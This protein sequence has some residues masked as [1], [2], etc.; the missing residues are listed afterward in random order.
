MEGE[1]VISLTN[2]ILL[3]SFLEARY[4]QI[5]HYKMG[6]DYRKSLIS[7]LLETTAVQLTDVSRRNKITLCVEVV[8]TGSSLLFA[9]VLRKNSPVS[10]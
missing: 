6:I 4:N 9:S 1:Q 3:F 5:I 8:L 7:P 2:S 10:T